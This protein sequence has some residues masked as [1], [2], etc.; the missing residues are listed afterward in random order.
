MILTGESI[1]GINFMFQ[2]H[3]QGQKVNSK[4]KNVKICVLTNIKSNTCNICFWCD[5]DLIINLK[6]E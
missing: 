3:F 2:G 6:V 1:C 4:V 5:F